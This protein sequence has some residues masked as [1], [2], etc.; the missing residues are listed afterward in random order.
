[1]LLQYETWISSLAIPLRL[2][3]PPPLL[4]IVKE[5]GCYAE[6][7]SDMEYE[8]AEHI[9]FEG[10][11]II[12]NGPVKSYESILKAINNQSI[13]NVDSKYEIEHLL[14]IRNEY[15]D[16]K[17]QVGLRVNMVINTNH[18]Q[19]AIQDG[20][21][22]SHFGFSEQDLSSVVSLL[23]RVGIDIVSLHGHVSS[24]NRSVE[25]YRIITKTLLSLCEE[26]QLDKVK[27]LD[28]GGGFFGAAPEGLNISHRPTYDSYAEG[29]YQILSFN[30][31]YH[32]HK[33]Y[34]VI[35]PGTSVVANVFDVV[36]KIH[37]HKQIHG[38]NFVTIDASMIN[39]K[40]LLGKANYLFTLSSSHSEAE[41]I[42]TDVVGSTCMERDIVLKD[43]RLRHYSYGDY[44]H[45]KGVGAYSL[46]MTPSFINYIFPIIECKD[47]QF[48]LARKKQNLQN[49]L[50]LYV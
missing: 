21:A 14:K 42:V 20:Y 38:K 47:G 24:G 41:E 16:K 33:P 11:H 7:V 1:M 23:N 2:I 25:N 13:L 39:V 19:S 49:I 46:S 4:K 30:E 44:I 48:K 32:A 10:S 8:L 5:S 15:P 17:V 26:Y 43:V 31:W 37:Q 50:D 12:Y 3:L 34:L 36:S 35:E 40:T 29:I 45:F 9:G 18:N 6:V 27:Y 28:L 22:F